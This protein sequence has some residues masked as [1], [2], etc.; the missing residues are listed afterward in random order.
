[1]EVPDGFDGGEA[2]C[3]RL[4]AEESVVLAP[5]EAFDRPGWFRIGYGLPREEL[6][7][8]L[9]RVGAFLDRHT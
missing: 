7:E 6:A 3:R 4:V 8:G 9:A 5:G 2:F 1:V